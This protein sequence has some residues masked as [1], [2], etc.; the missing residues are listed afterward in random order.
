MKNQALALFAILASLLASGSAL[1]QNNTFRAEVPF[2]F[3]I[4]NQELPAG[5]YQFERLLGKPL[6]SDAIG[7]VAVR[8][9]EL[10]IYEVVITRLSAQSDPTESICKLSFRRHDG[11][12]YLDQVWIAGDARRQMFPVAFPET[13]LAAENAPG[14]EIS[15]TQLR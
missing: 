15:M 5:S 9:R 1:A 13:H 14:D 12:R 10:H 11:Q 6:S 8:N 2:A 4:G 7:M 3:V